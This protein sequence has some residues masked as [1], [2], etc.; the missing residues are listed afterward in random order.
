MKD[1][2]NNN[3]INIFLLLENHCITYLV[4][5]EKTWN[6]FLQNLLQ[7]RTEK[8][9][10]S[11]NSNEWYLFY[12]LFNDIWCYL[13]IAC[14]EWCFWTISCKAKLYPLIL[15]EGYD[16]CF[17]TSGT[18]TVQLTVAIDFYFFWRCWPKACKH[19][20]SDS[21]EFVPCNYANEVVD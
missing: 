11:Q 19:S 7:N 6:V 12:W 9:M 4:A 16:N 14:F 2:N 8:Q 20:K 1:I 17:Q 13:F 3:K 10:P 18:W 5:K 21:I 15:L